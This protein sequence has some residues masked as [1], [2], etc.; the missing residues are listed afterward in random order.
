MAAQFHVI[1]RKMLCYKCI[2]YLREV[3]AWKLAACLWVYLFSDDFPVKA[4]AAHIFYLWDESCFMM[5]HRY[6]NN[7]AVLL[8]FD[9]SVR[10]MLR[11]L[12]HL[13]L[14]TNKN[15]KSY[16]SKCSMILKR[17]IIKFYVWLTFKKNLGSF[18]WKLWIF[19]ANSY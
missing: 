14:Q 3:N 1:H 6:V 8:M 19:Y 17:K 4:N 18:R 10:M 16:T 7:K 12:L 9:V 5:Y 11:N 2:F 15:V 13:R